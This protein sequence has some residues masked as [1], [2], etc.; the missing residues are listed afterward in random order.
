[1]KNIKELGLEAIQLEDQ[2]LLVDENKPRV[3]GNYYLLKNA[4]GLD[5]HEI[6]EWTES[7]HSIL[8]GKKSKSTG[9]IIASTKPLEGLPLL[10]IEDYVNIPEFD[11]ELEKLRLQ[12]GYD[13]AR[14]I[15]KFTEEDLRK[16]I[17]MARE[18]LEWDEKWGWLTTKTE[19][20]IIESITK[21]ELWVEVE[22]DHDDSVPHPKT[23][24][25]G[26]VPRIIDNQIKA[27]WK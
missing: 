19:D 10:V 27:A 2:V 17:S 25:S 26:Y 21:K 18:T 13:K 15:F 9:V 20:E 12:Q 5:K 24:G 4:G 8:S 6:T 16:A 1:M 11:L 22:Y 7:K 23:K 14:Q 3:Y